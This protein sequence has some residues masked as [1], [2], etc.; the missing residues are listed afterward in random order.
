MV[1][2]GKQ[3]ERK[4]RTSGAN[5]P[6]NTN[7]KIM[8]YAFYTLFFALIIN[9]FASKAQDSTYLY[10][11]AYAVIDSMVTGN[12]PLSLKKSVFVTE[13]A[14]LDNQLNYIRFEEE[15]NMLVGLV[16]IYKS[17]F[18]LEYSEE[19][20]E[21]VETIFSIFKVL[22]D[23]IS[24]DLGESNSFIHY[25]FSYEFF[26]M[27]GQTFWSN[28]FVSK[29]LASK[30]GNCH[31]FPF[32]FKILT[33]E[34][35]VPSYISFAPNHIYTK[36]YCRKTGWYNIELTSATFPVDAWIMASG[37]VHLDAIRNGLYMDT[38]SLQ[39]SVAYCLLDL[40]HGYQKKFGK[41]NPDFVIRC[42]NAVLKYHPVNVN[43]M[44]TKAEAQKSFIDAKM[45]E[46]G[47][48]S[49]QK[50]FVDDSIKAMYTDMEQTYIRLHQLGYRR[51][52]EEMY[53]QW[54]GVLKN[55]PQKYIDNK[56]F[57]KINNQ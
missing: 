33:E 57:Y 56:G 29:L 36:S 34:F 19:D 25:P 30:R 43:A 1:K 10:H 20:K 55:E 48:Q 17:N 52:P 54:M 24:I 21:T 5:A 49:P 23:T 26:D 53:L 28:M 7:F 50:L 51:M 42:C 44:L 12:T 35:K 13:N 14:Y 3:R 9:C 6:I 39:Q 15:I 8:R 18:S 41:S 11:E 27:W 32:L 45:K 46:I 4:T 37:Y 2:L 47:I 22:T 38:L 16:N 31:S 40:A